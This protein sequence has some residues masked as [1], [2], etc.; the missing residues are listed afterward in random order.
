[1]AVVVALRFLDKATI[2]LAAQ[3]EANKL[4]MPILAFAG[5][6]CLVFFG[7][8]WFGAITSK[9]I[10]YTMLGAVDQAAGAVFGIFRMAFIV[11][12]AAFGLQM[13][14]VSIRP[15]G[16]ENMVLL[17]AILQLGPAGFS[18]LAPLLPFLKKLVQ[19]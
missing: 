13:M 5:L 17:P 15:A 7:L 2:F 19:V 18:V 10:R 6:F 16:I 12:S 4:F 3:I 8:R 14:G 11:S 9:S 1:M